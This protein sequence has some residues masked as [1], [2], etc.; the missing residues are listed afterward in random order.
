MKI[1][2]III[3]IFFFGAVFAASAMAADIGDTTVNFSPPGI[4]DTA[5]EGQRGVKEQ[6]SRPGY[7][8]QCE[9]PAQQDWRDGAMEGQRG[10]PQQDSRFGQQMAGMDRNR[11]EQQSPG[12]FG[13]GPRC[14]QN[15][16]SLQ[17]TM[18]PF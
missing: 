9:T 12:Y 7:S 14:E 11:P 16:A 2:A 1:K 10:V 18:R 3:N 15:F 17:Y 4:Q 6:E 5:A 13:S 8:A